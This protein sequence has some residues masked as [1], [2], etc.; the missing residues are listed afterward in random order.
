MSIFKI[1]IDGRTALFRLTVILAAAMAVFLLAG[2]SLAAIKGKTFASPEEAVRALVAA[3]ESNDMKELTAILGPGS[4]DV[5]FSGDAVA[6]RE[7]REQFRKAYDEKNGLSIKGNTAILVIGN[8]DWP[9]PIP[10]VKRDGAW[11]FDTARGR[12]EILNR[13]IGRNELNTIQTLLAIV[14]AQREYAMEDSI[15]GGIQEYARR[16][17]SGP[18]KKD[19]LY[20]PTA[21]GE[22]PSPLGPLVAQAV[23]KGYK[24]KK[25]GGGPAPYQGYYYRMLTAQGSHAPDGAYGY[26]VHGKMIGGFAVVAHPARYGN[27]GVMTFIVNQDGVVYQKDLGRNTEKVEQKITEFDPDS[28]WRK[29][30]Q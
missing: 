1:C 7:G 10:I 29:V 21:E 25:P 27:T 19:G 6:D 17:F 11:H 14:D 28:T 13:R 24:A 5:L 8:G 4:R 22:Q 18:G 2:S 23:E 9:F 30:E 26:I 15:H 20:W 3:G 12:E 16:F